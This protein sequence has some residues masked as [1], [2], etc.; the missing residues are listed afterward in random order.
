MKSDPNPQ[1]AIRN[2]QPEGW[3]VGASIRRKEDPRLLRGMGAYTDDVRLPGMLHL[4]ALRSPHAHARIR[5]LDPAPALALPG[6]LQVVT[7]RDIAGRVKPF[8]LVHSIPDQ[9]AH[10][11]E[12]LPADTVRYAGQVVAA[13]VAESRYLAEDALEA[14][15]V[16]Y[17]PLPPVLDVEEALRPESPQLYDGWGDNRI[18]ELQLGMADADRA[19]AA[20]DLVLEETFRIGRQAAV[21][22]EGRAIVAAY[23]PHAARLTVWYSTQAPNP[24]RTMLA[25]MLGLEEH[26]IRIVAKDVGGGFGVK[27]HYY[28]EEVLACH[29]AVQRGRPV[30]FVEDRR[31]HF[32]STVHAR[33]QTIRAAAG[34]RRDG[35]LCALRC[36]VLADQG[37]HLHTKGASPAFLTARIFPGPYHVRA[38]RSTVT[39][40]ATSKV[41]SGA[42][43]GFGQP[44]A[45]FAMERLIEVAAGRLGLD[46]NDI[47]RKNFI[48]PEAFPY[49]T[50]SNFVYDSGNYPEAL[51]RALKSEA[52]RRIAA[53]RDRRRAAGRCAGVGL[54]FYL[55]YTGLGPSKILKSVGINQG[56]YESGIVRLDP[57]GRVTATTGLINTGQG[58]ETILAQVV[59][60]TLG[61]APDDVSVI[62]GDTD[63]C[64]Y[65]N[66]G[67]AASRGAVMGGGSM[68]LA[69]RA[70]RERL[71]AIAAHTLETAPDDIVLE[72]G[73]A[74]VRG[75]PGRGLSLRALAGIAYQGGQL[76]EGMEPGLEVKRVYDP[77]TWSYSYG[78]HLAGVDVDVETGAVEVLHYHIVHDCGATINP[79]IVD[80]QLVGGLAQGLGGALMEDLAYDGDGQLLT[81]TLMDYLIPT[82]AE[83]PP[84]SLEHME[85]RSPFTPGGMKG[86]AEGSLCGAPACVGNAVADALSPLGEAPIVEYPLTPERVWRMARR[87]RERAGVGV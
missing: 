66:Y 41:P 58:H 37:A 27:L 65:S 15:R 34:F 13:L 6:V 40:V 84:V 60:D 48:P 55:E 29:V 77:Q 70:M 16:A 33:Q 8:Q 51:E 26:Q 21:P 9:R 1:S 23:D 18:L 72:G 68:L 49:R 24:F 4:A 43:R 12:V 44:Q 76:P 45:A 42:Y 53:E 62:Q 39:G 25:E 46:A 82:A 81:A 20:A 50:A 11:Y 19:F 31:E 61:V 3:W 59:A 86:M 57:S 30:K 64:P 10:S 36:H 75:S 78:V 5:S 14:V 52:Y 17:E 54:A 67:T 69:A 56:G 2:P 47:R 28:P 38:Y 85:T 74:F 87:L 73:A 63:L 22:L 79:V 7:A 80:G 32:L 35:T 71:V 83:M